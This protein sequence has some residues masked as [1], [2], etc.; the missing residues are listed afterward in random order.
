ME[1]YVIQEQK[2]N[3]IILEVSD[4]TPYKFYEEVIE[5]LSELYDKIRND[6]SS[7]IYAKKFDNLTYSEREVI[8]EKYPKNIRHY[9]DL[10]SIGQ[11]LFFYN[12]NSWFIMSK[13]SALNFWVKQKGYYSK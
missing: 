8:I 11:L 5:L 1:K 3:S 4:C 6:E 7:A 10:F 13:I 12:S 9:Y 2:N